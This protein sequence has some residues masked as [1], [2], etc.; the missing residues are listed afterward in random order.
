ML[1]LMRMRHD[2]KSTQCTY[3]MS[4]QLRENK[5]FNGNVEEKE[6]EL[7]EQ[8]RPQLKRK[9]GWE[10]VE[11]EIRRGELHNATIR[12]VSRLFKYKSCIKCR[13]KADVTS[14]RLQGAQMLLARCCK[15]WTWQRKHFQQS[16]WS[17]HQTSQ[18]KK[19][20]LSKLNFVQS[21]ILTHMKSMRKTRLKQ[22]HL[23]AAPMPR[24]FSQAFGT[25]SSSFQP[26]HLTLLS[27]CYTITH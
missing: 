27:A 8:Q 11:R 3:N 15:N 19:F 24:V 9:K 18:R 2:T 14:P 16:W 5:D 4:T 13:S 21:L 23:I 6:S 12:G 26:I 10:N 1:Q 22:H 20:R 7:I 17:L 25:L